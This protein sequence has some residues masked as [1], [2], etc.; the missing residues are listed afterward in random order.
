MTY[1]K[2]TVRDRQKTW[3]QKIN[4]TTGHS[5]SRIA[6]EVGLAQTTISRFMD[7][8]QSSGA[9]SARTEER[10][11]IR[12][13]D[14]DRDVCESGHVSPLMY[15]KKSHESGGFGLVTIPEYDIQISAGGGSAVEAEESP[16]KMWTIPRQTVLSLSPN[17]NMLRIITVRGDSMEPDY[18]PGDKVLVDIGQSSY[19]HDGVYAL[20]FGFGLVLKSLQLIVG[21]KPAAVEV[22]SKNAVYPPQRVDLSQAGIKGRIVARWD[23]K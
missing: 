3:L 8:N 18:R 12:Y 4:H 14:F 22:I 7:D 20:D 5:Y 23:Q 2:T 15:P 16:E 9:L 21:S 10:I 6:K 17:P 11:R 19:T 1:S 13:G